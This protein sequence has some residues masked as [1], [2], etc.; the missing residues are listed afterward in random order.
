MVMGPLEP[1]PQTSH[2]WSLN[3]VSTVGSACL[4]GK[5]PVTGGWLVVFTVC[6]GVL[7]PSNP[8]KEW[9]MSHMVMEH[10][11]LKS[12]I[13]HYMVRDSNITA[14][15]IPQRLTLWFEYKIGWYKQLVPLKFYIHV[16]HIM[17][18]GGRRQG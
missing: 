11:S 16:S 15:N 5:L 10:R 17:V 3:P 13:T 14:V 12:I 8:T 1:S 2:I 6:F 9:L 7:P 4:W 18:A